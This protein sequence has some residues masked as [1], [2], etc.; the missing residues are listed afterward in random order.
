MAGKQAILIGVDGYS[1]RPLTSAVNDAVA[2]RDAL[3]GRSTPHL[4]PIFDDADVTLL[5]TPHAN[6]SSNPGTE[7]ATRDA[8]LRTLKSHYDTTDPASLILVYFAGHGLA[9]SPDGRV[10]ETLI[11]PS[12]V[13]GPEAGRNMISLDQLLHLFAER[14]PLQQLWIIDACRDMPYQRRPRGYEIDW[15]EQPPQSQRVQVSIFAVA[16][17]GEAISTSGGQGR[18]TEYLLAGLAGK[19]SAADYIPGRG[20]VVTAQSLHEYARRR[21]SEA[22]EGYDDWTRTIQTPQIT[23]ANATLEPL[24]DLPH[25]RDRSQ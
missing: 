22:L 12:D 14:G 19:G 2:M 5:V 10:R 16:Q 24:R 7:L 11:L 8:I 21:I 9:V 23:Q 4:Q 1:F 25:R 3:V 6:A 17:G 13:T 20:H 18:F 15:T